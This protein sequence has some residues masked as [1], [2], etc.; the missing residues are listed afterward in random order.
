MGRGKNCNAEITWKRRQK[1]DE[2]KYDVIQWVK[3]VG[4]R[5]MGNVFLLSSKTLIPTQDSIVTI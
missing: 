1:N 5:R 3:R 4:V 2:N